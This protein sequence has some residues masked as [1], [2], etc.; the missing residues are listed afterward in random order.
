[1]IS[2][3]SDDRTVLNEADRQ[4]CDAP[5]IQP[6]PPS[7]KRPRNS[8]AYVLG[9]SDFPSTSIIS[10]LNDVSERPNNRSVFEQLDNSIA[11][12]E[13]DTDPSLANVNAEAPSPGI[14]PGINNAE[15]IDDRIR[16]IVEVRSRE[17]E[18]A[19][20]GRVR[21]EIDRTVAARVQEVEVGFNLTIDR[22]RQRI[23][24]LESERQLAPPP[25]PRGRSPIPYHMNLAEIELS[26][27][28][29]QSTHDHDSLMPNY[30][31]SQDVV[32][33]IK[34]F[35]RSRRIFIANI[36]RKM[37]S[38]QERAQDANTAGSKNRP[39]LSP[40][41]SR[42]RRICFY[43]AQQY[44]IPRDETLQSEV[45]KTMDDTNRRY[46]DDL[47]VRKIRRQDRQNPE[48]I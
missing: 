40:T 27:D 45:R 8:P 6:K 18:N 1:M 23:V 43:T 5:E 35:S 29:V 10:D 32:T 15:R 9:T 2:F 28:D 33:S 47:K 14:S 30:T 21:D 3:F 44:N 12:I 34:E 46:R 19:I 17:I 39:A 13:S 22:L 38:M 37:F 48:R 25:P 26:P 7:K 24:D 16:E 11:P 31:L 36:T 4:L 42:Y 41:K 20:I